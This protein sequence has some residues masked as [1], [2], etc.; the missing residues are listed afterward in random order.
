[1]LPYFELMNSEFSVE[2]K[3]SWENPKRGKLFIVLLFQVL[4]TD[5]LMVGDAHE[6]IIGH[7]V[8]W[9]PIITQS[10]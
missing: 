10:S 3:N 1:M 4:K 8:F 9:G 7:E 2:Q 6:V 5:T